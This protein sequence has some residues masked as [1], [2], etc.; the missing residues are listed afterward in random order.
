VLPATPDLDERTGDRAVVSEIPGP[1]QHRAIR[2][3]SAAV[4]KLRIDRGELALGAGGEVPPAFH[5]SVPSD[6]AG[7]VIASGDRRERTRRW[8]GG[9]TGA[10][11]FD[12]RVF[13]QAAAVA[14]PRSDLC[15]SGLRS[16]RSRAGPPAF[17]RAVRPQTA[18]MLVLDDHLRK[19][20][21]RRSEDA[22]GNVAPA[23]RRAV[24][25]KRAAASLVN[26]DTLKPAGGKLGRKEVRVSLSPALQ[27]SIG[28]YAASV[29]KVGGPL[30][31]ATLGCFDAY[32]EER[33][34]E[35]D[36]PQKKRNLQTHS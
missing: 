18:R 22:D 8:Q 36:R 28:S 19:G 4:D 29:L 24:G 14:G 23:S 20:A 34:Q 6:S 10:P 31:E 3:K 26:R 27:A 32:R 11:A 5:C 17:R 25:A 30:H 33:G 13:S 21:C 12:R 9:G 2:S 7:S 35:A 15:E 16:V 1:A